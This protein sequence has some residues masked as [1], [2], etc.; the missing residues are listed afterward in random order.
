MPT[1]AVLRVPATTANLGP[2]FDCVGMALDIYD[3]VT[4][5][6]GADP[7]DDTGLP[8]QHLALIRLAARRCYESA[9]LT[10][11]P[12]KAACDHVIPIGRGMGSSAAA[13]V[14]GVAG[15]NALAGS[16]LTPAA[17]AE[18]AA[19]IEGH[20]DNST[21]CFYGG[22]HVCVLEDGRLTDV[23]VP[24]PAGLEAV[25]FIPD[26]PMN[27]HETRK[28]LPQSLSRGDVVF[29]VGRAAVLVAAL[30]TGA[31]GALRFATQDKLHQPARGA[32]FSAMFPLFDAAL[33]AGAACAF[34]SGGGPTVLALAANDAP[35]IGAAFSAAAKRLGVNG[36]VRITRPASRGTEILELA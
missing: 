7:L 22:L 1:K 25:L 19:Q 34:L 11:P 2:G 9:G 16:P 21:P 26:F 23:A 30:A 28:L 3:T 6:L 24:L 18:L 20:P 33:E 12:L 36:E 32:V 27:T 4:L 5:E 35:A 14:A 13:I 29:Q 8:G 15:A 31:T 10:V 17:V